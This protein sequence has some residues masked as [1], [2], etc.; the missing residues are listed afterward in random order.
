MVGF[1][2]LMALDL[3]VNYTLLM[4]DYFISPCAARRIF[5]VHPRFRCMDFGRIVL[6]GEA[7]FVLHPHTAAAVAK[8]A[9]DGMV[10]GEALRDGHDLAE[11]CAALKRRNCKWD[12]TSVTTASA[13]ATNRSFHVGN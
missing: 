5:M 6:V 13:R 3:Y 2:L 9:S 4:R 10:L 8:A 7:A 1:F 11:N 12:F